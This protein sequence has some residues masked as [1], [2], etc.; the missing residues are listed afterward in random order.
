MGEALQPLRPHPPVMPYRQS[1]EP[2]PPI[3][4]PEWRQTVYGCLAS[5]LAVLFAVPTVG[6][7]LV[8]LI[9]AIVL[10]KRRLQWHRFAAVALICIGVVLLLLGTCAVIVLTTM[11][12]SSFR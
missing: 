7:S 5:F 4:I 6:L 8:A 1:S 12:S 11:S 9:V 3:D 10:A 2:N